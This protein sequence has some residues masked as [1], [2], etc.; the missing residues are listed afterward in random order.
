MHERISHLVALPIP[1]T[2]PL[3]YVHDKSVLPGTR[4]LVPLGKRTITGTVVE[5]NT[6]EWEGAREIVE[7]LDETPAITSDVLELTRRISEYYLC[8][9]GEAIDASIPVGLTPTS[10]VR[11]SLVADVTDEDLATM[12]RRA[13]KRA[14]LLQLLR[15]QSGDVTV[16]YLQKQ[17][18]STTIA[19]QL[20]ALHRIGVLS[21]ETQIERERGPRQVQ[22]LKID[23]TFAS[24][25]E[26]VRA[27]FDALDSRAP[28]QSLLLGHLYLAHHKGEGALPTAPIIKSLGISA[29]AVKSL[30]EKGLVQEETVS[31]RQQD[32]EFAISLAASDETALTLTEEQQQVVEKIKTGL[33]RYTPYLLEGI[34]GSGKTVVYAE[35]MKRVLEQGR[36]CLLLVPEIALTPQL[37]DRM[38]AWFGNKVALLHSGMA[39]GERIATWRDIRAG[40]VQIVVGARSAVFAPIENL[41]LVIVDEEHEPSYKQNDPAPRYHGRDAAV[42]R[43]LIAK[44]PIVLGSATPSLESVYNA[45]AGKYELLRLTQRIDGAMLPDIELVD[46]REQRKQN[47]MHGTLSAPLVSDVF[48][49][50]EHKQ[51]VILFLNRRGYS[52]QLQCE[53]C[54]AV[55]ECPNCDVSLTYHK[56]THSL[57]CHYCGHA[58]PARTA[59]RVC[60]GIHLTETGIGTQ[61]V[62]EDLRGIVAA[63]ADS[64]KM[65]IERMDTDTMRKRGS[66]RKL[67]TRF[68]GGDVDVVI[69]TQM[70]GKGLDIPRVTLVGVVNADQSLY[71]SDFR[72]SE[73]TVQLLVQ[74][75][76]R[77]G[78]TAA[79][80]GKVVVQTSSPDHPAIV[81]ASVLDRSAWLSEELL[82]RKELNYPPYSRF[83]VIELSGA[84]EQAVE[85]AARIIS[86]L[87]PTDNPA[88]TS[89][90]PTPPSISRIRNRYRRVIILKNHR[91]VDPSGSI[92][93]QLLN[94]ALDAYFNEHAK[95]S[96]RVVVDIDHSGTL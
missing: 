20:D 84:D 18:K 43:A 11:V 85:H 89:M 13:P 56:A 93:R 74:V 73:R 94:G 48:K 24:D 21:I 71:Q 33:G 26:K 72:A 92:F 25:E 31:Q 44:C 5:S 17:L 79:H 90:P 39:I 87:I 63:S 45:Q 64:N 7:V 54:G 9:W 30:I 70:V 47:K 41:G 96:V 66:H 10:V 1:R 23:P 65:N 8:S 12:Q 2:G 37:H 81:A 76:G 50:V 67:L 88:V 95:S 49:R 59:C 29:A 34:T 58:E 16:E 86:R 78:R 15:S 19:Q 51:G 62:E 61:R 27:T 28:K 53:D 69:G 55:P 80:A 22:A 4:V 38:K 57:R 52:S 32:D 6:P 68:A 3:S 35:V 46:I 82:H 42:L 91:S 77:A 75:S 60:G 36:T 40:A 14:E 83:N